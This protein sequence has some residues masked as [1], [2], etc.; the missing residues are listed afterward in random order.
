MS[1]QSTGLSRD[2]RA[3]AL[4]G[5]RDEP[6]KNEFDMMTV[7]EFCRRHQISA[8]TYY[9][10]R[11]LGLGPDEFRFGSVV[12]ISNEAAAR[13]RAARE[14]PVGA[15]AEAIARNAVAMKERSVAAASSSIASPRHVSARRRAAARGE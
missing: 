5:S 4:A 9:Q 11:K 6:V 3:G 2:E 8:P 10:L 7:A 14:R 13:W 15:E 1:A 12:R